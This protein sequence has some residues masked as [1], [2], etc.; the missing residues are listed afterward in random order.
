MVATWKRWLRKHT[1][2]KARV[3]QSGYTRLSK[4]A[5]DCETAVQDAQLEKIRSTIQE[6]TDFLALANRERLASTHVPESP[7]EGD[8]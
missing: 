2:S 5:L 8:H 1:G 7:P 3:E 4:L 6:M